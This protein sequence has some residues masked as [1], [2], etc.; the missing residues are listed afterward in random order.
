MLRK[1]PICFLHF[2][3]P[4]PPLP[5]Q[6]KVTKFCSINLANSKLGPFI[7]CSV[8]WLLSLCK[9]QSPHSPS[10][11]PVQVWVINH[12]RC[13][14]NSHFAVVALP[15]FF[16]FKYLA[17]DY[18]FVPKYNYSLL[19]LEIPS[20]SLKPALFAH[21]HAYNLF[22]MNGFQHSENNWF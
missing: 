13:I 2:S 8:L 3:P 21:Y 7:V 12:S 18:F 15:F 22:C 10:H 11:L 4:P 9:A 19:I 14:L 5:T 16:L 17:K 6:R 20:A 1:V